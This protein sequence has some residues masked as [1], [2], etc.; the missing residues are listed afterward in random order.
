M[1]CANVCL[2]VIIDD[3]QYK[4]RKD[5][6]VF[7][8]DCF[9]VDDGLCS[10]KNEELAVDL[11]KSLVSLCKKGG[12]ELAKFVSSFSNVL[13]SLNPKLVSSKIKSGLF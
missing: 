7:I 11:I 6:A 3:Y 1:G 12:I 10:V 9:Y 8:C 4:H 5:A 13:Q 2:K